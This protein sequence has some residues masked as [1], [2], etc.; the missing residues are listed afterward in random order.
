VVTL[1][2]HRRVWNLGSILEG[3]FFFRGRSELIYRKTGGNLYFRGESER[4]A[5]RALSGTWKAHIQK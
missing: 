2:N 4:R 1:M 5:A 3:R